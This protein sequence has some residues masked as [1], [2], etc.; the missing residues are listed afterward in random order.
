MVFLFCI[1]LLLLP[2]VFWMKGLY[3]WF[4]LLCCGFRGRRN[5]SDG[6]LSACRL[7][8]ISVMFCFLSKVVVFVNDQWWGW[9]QLTMETVKVL[10]LKEMLSA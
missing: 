1:R 9:S 8:Y 2:G 7:I 4:V 5:W 3:S 6:F 10:F